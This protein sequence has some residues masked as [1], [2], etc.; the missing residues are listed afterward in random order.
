MLVTF[1]VL[2][3]KWMVVFFTATKMHTTPYQKLDDL[4]SIK[5]ETQKKIELV[6]N[7]DI[8]VQTVE[9]LPSL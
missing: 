2:Y 8:T 5:I 3:Y 1:L 4:K 7:T 9:L 6:L